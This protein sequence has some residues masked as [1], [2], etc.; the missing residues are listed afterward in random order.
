MPDLETRAMIRRLYEVENWK[1]GTIARELGIHHSTV[2][3]ALE[4]KELSR[5]ARET[6]PILDGYEEFVKDTLERF[7][8]LS[9]TRIRQMLQARGY[10]GSTYPVRRL[11]RQLR[12]KPVRAFQDIHWIAGEAAQVDWGD[13]GRIEVSPGSWRR[14]QLFAMVLCHSRAFFGWFFHDQKT[15]ALLEGHVRAFNHWGGS[16]RR[17]IYDNMR[18]AVKAN[19]GHSVEFTTSLLELA[20]HYRF[21]PVACNPRAGWEKGKVENAIRYVRENFSVESRSFRNL[22]DL[23]KQLTEWIARIADQRDLT[24][25]GKSVGE[26]LMEEK[27]VLREFASEFEAYDE[28]ISKVSK[29]AMVQYD[30]NLYTV[31]PEYVGRSLT[32]RIDSSQIRIFSESSMVAQHKRCW[33]KGRK[34]VDR[35]HIESLIKQVHA[36]SPRQSRSLVVNQIP[37][38]PKLLQ[39]WKHRLEDLAFQ[40]RQLGRLIGNFGA[41]QVEAAVQ[42]AL[43]LETTHV[44]SIEH[45]LTQQA[46]PPSVSKTHYNRKKLNNDYVE[47]NSLEEYDEL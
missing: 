13:F 19:L 45:I 17:V 25:S 7:P 33:A 43:E 21:E 3:R 38:G 32:L 10:K 2:K 20:D 28:V 9:A 30:S 26:S 34:I 11:V 39:A 37:S 41:K 16:P 47:R 42:L 35:T 29:K 14:I 44:D 12:P 24:G 5:E 6:S 8:K 23:N 22:C 31:P 1:V 4:G 15:A 40:S 36:R 46:L 27:K 18:T